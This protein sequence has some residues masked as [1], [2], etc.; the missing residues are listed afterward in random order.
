[1]F[2]Q[3]MIPRNPVDNFVSCIDTLSLV[4]LR[5]VGFE[6]MSSTAASMATLATLP[7][8]ELKDKIAPM[9]T[10][11]GLCRN[12]ADSFWRKAMA[13]AEHHEDKKPNFVHVVL[14]CK[15]ETKGKKKH[16]HIFVIC[17]I[18]NQNRMWKNTKDKIFQFR[19]F[20]DSSTWQKINSWTILT[21]FFFSWYI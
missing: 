8:V 7:M 4:P 5:T 11:L 3:S 20:N 2:V 15:N 6:F 18:E 12:I 21:Y 16:T 9:L 17:V 14:Y 13:L 19:Y 1:M 10:V